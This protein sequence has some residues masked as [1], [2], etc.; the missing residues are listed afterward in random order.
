MTWQLRA[1]NAV[2][3]FKQV[4]NGVGSQ[5]I[6]NPP[7][8]YRGTNVHQF[9]G[10]EAKITPA[11]SPVQRLVNKLK[12]RQS[13]KRRQ[14]ARPKRK[15]PKP[16]YATFNQVRQNVPYGG[17]KQN[18]YEFFMQNS[19]D[20]LTAQGENLDVL[21]TQFGIDTSL[22]VQEKQEQVYTAMAD[23]YLHGD[24]GWTH[25]KIVRL[26]KKFLETLEKTHFLNL[27]CNFLGLKE[28]MV[29]TWLHTDPDFAEQFNATQKRFGERIAHQTLVKAMEGDFGAQMY[30]LKQFGDS[31]QFIES[32]VVGP[33]AAQSYGSMNIDNLSVEEQ[34]TLLRLM[35]KAQVGTPIAGPTQFDESPLLEDDTNPE[36][37][38]ASDN[39]DNNEP[40]PTTTIIE[41]SGD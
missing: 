32:D 15:S 28:S 7:Q 41:Y 9:D 25:E 2:D 21:A 16:N 33:T 26:K 18:K 35:R 14:M 40:T 22:P 10:V 4:H 17:K 11:V 34:E 29:K 20:I 39:A 30:V 31:V 27:T 13:E 12:K 19:D 38:H 36:L 6:G 37:S 8:T 24:V 23:K 3:F 1:E 5:S